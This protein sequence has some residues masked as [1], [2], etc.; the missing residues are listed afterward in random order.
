MKKW[1]NNNNSY[2][3]FGLAIIWAFTAPIAAESNNLFLG[4]VGVALIP[5]VI[6][7]I[8]VYKRSKA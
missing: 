5:L 7:T 2:F 8:A 1:W 6:I 4:I 3:L